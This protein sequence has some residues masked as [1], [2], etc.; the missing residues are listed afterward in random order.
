MAAEGLEA[1]RLAEHIEIARSNGEKILADPGIALDAITHRQATFTS[2]DLAMFV[3]RHSDGKE[4]F[5]AV[6]SAVKSSPELVAIGQD[7]RGDDR[8]TSRAMIETEER[9]E[10]GTEEQRVGKEGGRTWRS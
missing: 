4:Q 8:F 10:R 9:L 3:H 6:M 5:D 7:G 1:D 2:R